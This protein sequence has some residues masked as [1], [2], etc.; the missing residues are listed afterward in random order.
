V[1]LKID[2]IVWFSITKLQI[3]QL[4]LNLVVC[5]SGVARSVSN[6]VWREE[7]KIL[8][9]W[10]PDLTMTKERRLN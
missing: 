10:K 8:S 6:V 3:T 4:S 7:L 2:P 1:Q 5:S 9:H